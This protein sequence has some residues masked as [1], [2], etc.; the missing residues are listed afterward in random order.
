MRIMSYNIET[1]TFQDKYDYTGVDI[2]IYYFG[3]TSD[4][5]YF[6]GETQGKCF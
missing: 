5:A 4:I 3:I 6:V 2:W 1:D